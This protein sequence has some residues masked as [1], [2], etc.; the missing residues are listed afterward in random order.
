MNS[1]TALEMF[2]HNNIDN[3]DVI[4]KL[5][6]MLFKDKHLGNIRL[7]I[8]FNV[9]DHI[10][11]EVEI[12]FRIYSNTFLKIVIKND[13]SVL[14]IIKN[15]DKTENISLEIITLQILLL[16]ISDH[17]NEVKLDDEITRILFEFI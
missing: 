7:V 4:N 14:L 9:I 2:I 1:I 17:R 10:N 6:E 12:Y 5:L 15:M 13:N 11:K 8:E 16:R 3:E